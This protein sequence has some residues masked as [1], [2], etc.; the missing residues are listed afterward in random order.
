M[1]AIA[2]RLGSYHDAPPYGYPDTDGAAG[3]LDVP[4]SARLDGHAPG[5]VRPGRQPSG[6]FPRAVRGDQPRDL[7]PARYAGA[8]DGPPDRV[9]GSAGDPRPAV[10]RVRRSLADQADAG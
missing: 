4:R 7:P 10:G 6:R 2:S 9:H 1:G 8:G 3:A 5:V